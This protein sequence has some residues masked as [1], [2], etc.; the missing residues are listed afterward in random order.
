[1]AKHGLEGI[2]VGHLREFSQFAPHMHQNGSGGY[3]F[4]FS[5]DCWN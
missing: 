1:M 2:S 3:F 5:C 4:H